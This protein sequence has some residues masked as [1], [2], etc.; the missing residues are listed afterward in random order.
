M[1]DCCTTRPFA[2]LGQW[3]WSMKAN[4]VRKALVFTLTALLT[5]AT[6]AG[7]AISL[8]PGSTWDE[9]RSTPDLIPEAPMI[10]FGVHGV[11]VLDVCMHGDA[12][13]AVTSSGTTAETAVGPH[14]RH[15][16]IRVNRHVI[17]VGEHSYDR[18]LFTKPFDIP[19]CGEPVAAGVGSET[20]SEIFTP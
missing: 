1:K 13:R 5:V 19:A 14:R 17:V 15:Y 3:H 4:S 7:A 6:A 8:G 2:S 9:I 12:L 10:F 20:L 16:D 11:S 18:Y